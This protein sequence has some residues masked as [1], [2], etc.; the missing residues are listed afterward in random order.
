MLSMLK[1][2]FD[3]KNIGFYWD[4]GLNWRYITVLGKSIINIGNK[5]ILYNIFISNLRGDTH[6]T[7][8]LR[9]EG[10]WLTQKWD[11]IRRIGWGVARVLNVQSFFI[12]I[13]WICAM[14]RHA[15]SNNILLT[16]NLLID[17][18]IRHWSY[19]LMIPLH[20]LWAKLN[21][22]TR[23]QFGM[24]RSWLCFSF[25]FVRSHVRCDCCSTACWTGLGGFV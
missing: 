25:D 8:T 4:D 22:R 24:W 16:R 1:S 23:N 12:K 13:I 2:E 17:P 15:E 5:I 21:N 7:T 14:T 6:M 10:R 20:C 9:G 3:G 11:V 18:N 19:P